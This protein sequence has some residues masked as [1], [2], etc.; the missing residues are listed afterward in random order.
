[1]IDIT[2]QPTVHK[3]DISGYKKIGIYFGIDRGCQI[4][5]ADPI[6]Y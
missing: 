5:M 1:M 2:R 6:V 4:I 3:E